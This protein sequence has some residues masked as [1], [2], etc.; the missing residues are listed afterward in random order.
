LGAACINQLNNTIEALTN[1]D[2]HLA[3]LT[4]KADSK[5]NNLQSDVDKL[6]VKMLAMRQPVAGDLRNV[7]AGLRISTDLERIADYAA[8]ISQVLIDLKGEEIAHPMQLLIQMCEIA[9]EMLTEAISAYKK[10][11]VEL[12]IKVWHDDDKLDRTYKA[13]L[14]Q[15]RSCMTENKGTIDSCT[16]YI[17]GARC[18][19][20]MG[21]HI[22][23]V[24]EGIYYIRTGEKYVGQKEEERSDI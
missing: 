15:L 2:T 17:F 22:T 24:V 21:D 13:L 7:I 5:V 20:R 10:N 1:R 9:L 18:C 12:A 3:K 19:E 14:D 11:D 4:V 16:H 6:T 23:N 8:S